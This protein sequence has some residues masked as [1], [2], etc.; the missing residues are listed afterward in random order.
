MTL[1]KTDLY[2][3]VAQQA[4]ALMA[5]EKDVIANLANL[6]AL[7]FMRLPQLNWAGFYLLKGQELVLGP[8]QGK[9]ACI[10]IPVGRGVCG[11]A[12]ETGEAQCIEDV[13]A[14]VGHIA[15]DADSNAEA[16]VPIFQNGQLLGVLDLDS[17]Y[18]GRFD[19]DDMNGLQNL[20]NILQDAIA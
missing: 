10:R 17:P 2:Q 11:K 12:A 1:S 4:Q 3:E 19:Q 6:S 18:V 7:I 16:V 8:F 20:V 9:P 13:H 15:C 5:G 14:F